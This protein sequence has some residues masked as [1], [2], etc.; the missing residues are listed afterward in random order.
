ML[1]TASLT[2]DAKIA[3]CNSANI[4][5]FKH[6]AP[7]VWSRQS[8][9]LRPLRG[10]TVTE[11]FSQQSHYLPLSSSLECSRGHVTCDP[12]KNVTQI[13]NRLIIVKYTNIF[14]LFIL[15]FF[16]ILFIH[17][18]QRERQRYRQ[19][20]KQAPC[21]NPMWDSI[22]GPQDQALSQRQMLNCRATQ[23]SQI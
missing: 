2:A 14:K 13:C 9:V 4:I 11:L 8:R 17:E 12:C 16:K 10:S 3:E 6:T 21:G 22:P 15:F 5:Q 23:V 18:R 1:L 7:Q 20:K 19:R